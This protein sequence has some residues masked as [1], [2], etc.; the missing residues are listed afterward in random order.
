MRIPEND[1]VVLVDL[2]EGVQPFPRPDGEKITGPTEIRWGTFWTRR[3]RAG[4]IVVA[5]GE[6]G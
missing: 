6:E 1:T 5:D 3:L 2:A 4:E